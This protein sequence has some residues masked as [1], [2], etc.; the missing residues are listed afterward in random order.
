MVPYPSSRY[1]SAMVWKQVRYLISPGTGWGPWMRLLATSKG[2]FTQ[3]EMVP[4]TRP[5][6]NFLRNSRV[7]SWGRKQK[8]VIKHFQSGRQ[9]HPMAR[10]TGEEAAM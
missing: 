9:I 2:M 7:G 5:M 8:Y 6:V 4:D 10:S 3:E 1:T